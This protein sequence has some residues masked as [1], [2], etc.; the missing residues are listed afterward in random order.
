MKI[1]SS[2]LLYEQWF[3]GANVLLPAAPTVHFAPIALLFPG[4]DMP[5]AA[6]PLLDTN[7]V[8]GVAFPFPLAFFLSLFSPSPAAA[9]PPPPPPPPPP[10]AFFLVALPCGTAFFVASAP[11]GAALAFR[12]RGILDGSKRTTI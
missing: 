2:P 5:E 7:V 11:C 12:F 8:V 3:K 9:A 1:H 6:V 4:P 10:P